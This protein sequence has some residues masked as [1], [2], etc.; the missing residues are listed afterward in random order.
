MSQQTEPLLVRLKPL[1]QKKGILVERYTYKGIQFQEKRG[2]YSIKNH[3]F[4]E[5]LTELHQVHGDEST[6]KLFDVCTREQAMAL[7]SKEKRKKGA[8][9]TVEEAEE[10]TPRQL[11]NT[12]T[13]RD[14]AL[15]AGRQPG[16][17]VSRMSRLY[18]DEEKQREKERQGAGV[19]GGRNLLR[20]GTATA[21]R[22]EPEPTEPAADEEEQAHLD[23][24]EEGGNP[25]LESD[26]VPPDEESPE[27]GQVMEL[28]RVSD[29]APAP[30]K[31]AAEAQAPAKEKA[32]TKATPAA[33]GRTRGGGGKPKAEQRV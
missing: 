28:G 10:N 2:W 13:T 27:A 3:E 8:K 1:N 6:P 22:E 7:E 24:H 23:E 32:A 21:P 19:R 12:I 14:V 4:A 20:K 9:A 18:E 5:E 11:R 30:A 15:K 26:E 25:M 31:E 16:R 17:D 33:S 29:E